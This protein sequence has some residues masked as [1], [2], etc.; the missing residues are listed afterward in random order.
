MPEPHTP[1]A[2]VINEQAGALAQFAF[3]LSGV[4]HST[5][6]IRCYLARGPVVA[7]RYVSSVIAYHSAVHLLDIEQVRGLIAPFAPYFVQPDHT[8]Y[9]RCTDATLTAR[10]AAKGDR[11]RDDDDMMNVPGRLQRLR[12]NFDT[13]AAQD[14]TA[15]LIDTDDRSPAQLADLITHHM[16]SVDE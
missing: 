12:A 9:L 15:V 7:D 8:F 16:K 2:P 3:Y 13:T 14:P 6:L 5:D 10:M 4:L 11:N 1:W